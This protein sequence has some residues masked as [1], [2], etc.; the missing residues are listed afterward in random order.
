[1][2]PRD[3]SQNWVRMLHMYFYKGSVDIVRDTTLFIAVLAVLALISSV[4][5]QKHVPFCIVIY[6]FHLP[7]LNRE[8]PSM[9]K[10]R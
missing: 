2:K 5:I 3:F 1:M 6:R 9:P 10:Q 4:H 8:A 7:K